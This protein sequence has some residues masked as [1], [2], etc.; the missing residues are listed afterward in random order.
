MLQDI[1]FGVRMLLKSPMMTVIALLALMLG[2]GANT[3]IFSVV[4]AV[5]LRSFPY[6]DPERLV[7]VWE[8]K[9]GGRTDQN[10]INL[11]NFFDWKEQNQVFT[12]M[13]ALRS[14]G[15]NLTGDGPP[16]FVHAQRVTPNVFRILG[17]AALIGRT[18]TDDDDR[19]GEKVVVLS[20]RLWQRR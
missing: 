18:L 7:L 9:E 17:V 11:G 12:D 3:A 8:K 6:A 1:R 20:Y 5:L 2:I 16:D 4:N 14:M 10:V 19:A 15:A 13:A